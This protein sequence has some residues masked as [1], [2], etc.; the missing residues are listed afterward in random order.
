[1]NAHI[2]ASEVYLLI[3]IEFGGSKTAPYILGKSQ[4]SVHSSGSTLYGPGSDGS[5]VARF[6]I[7]ASAGAMLDLKSLVVSASVNNLATLPATGTDTTPV[8]FLSPS[9]SGLLASARVTITGLR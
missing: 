1:M 7:S 2:A 6:E 9:L 8:K 4:I 5:R 3:A